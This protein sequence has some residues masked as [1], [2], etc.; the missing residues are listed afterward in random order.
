M[1]RPS[2]GGVCRGRRDCRCSG[3]S[4][5][6]PQPSVDCAMKDCCNARSHD[7]KPFSK[8]WS[9]LSMGSMISNMPAADGIAKNADWSF[10]PNCPCGRVDPYY[11]ELIL[12]NR[13]LD[14]I[15]QWRLTRKEGK[16][17]QITSEEKTKDGRNENESKDK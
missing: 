16:N 6:C 4:G 10:I 8:T 17:R 2:Q 9:S 14:V 5:R 15:S 13:Q 1:H 12:A 11:N 7:C 3:C